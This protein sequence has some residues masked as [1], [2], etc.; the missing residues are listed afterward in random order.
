M[1]VVCKTRLWVAER[2]TS[3]DYPSAKHDASWSLPN[4][5][6]LNNFLVVGPPKFNQCPMQ[7]VEAMVTK[8]PKERGELPMPQCVWD[9]KQP[10]KDIGDSKFQR[11]DCLSPSEKT[12]ATLEGTKLCQCKVLRNGKQ[13]IEQFDAPECL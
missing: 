11:N 12:Y 2:L 10:V 9:W 13:V 6:H 8:T 3:Q 1:I 4:G 5:Y 7:V